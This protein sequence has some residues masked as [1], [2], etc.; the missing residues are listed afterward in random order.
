MK[1]INETFW[2]GSYYYNKFTTDHMAFVYF[3]FLIKYPYITI[4]NSDCRIVAR[5]FYKL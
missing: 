4:F 5:N 2:L 1:K 3:C